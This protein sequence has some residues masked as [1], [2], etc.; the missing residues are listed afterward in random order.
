LDLAIALGRLR[1][2]GETDDELASAVETITGAL[3]DVVATKPTI[4]WEGEVPQRG[5][6]R[7]LARVRPGSPQ[8]FTRFVT[9]R[10]HRDTLGNLCWNRVH[11]VS[12]RVFASVLADFYSLDHAAAE[13][14]GGNS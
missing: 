4:L 13:V 14:E 10:A 11:G 1:A 9:E 3:R 2:A 6:Y 7:V 5:R 8:G 12:R